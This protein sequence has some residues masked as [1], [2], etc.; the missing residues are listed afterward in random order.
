MSIIKTIIKMFSDV[1]NALSGKY[2]YQN[3][4]VIALK[5]E[6]KNVKTPTFRDDK[7]N[8]K[9]DMKNIFTSFK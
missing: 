1:H 3:E 6:L 4:D 8:L 7:K 9:E 2:V 5:S